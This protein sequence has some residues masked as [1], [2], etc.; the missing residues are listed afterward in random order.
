M[1]LGGR[2]PTMKRDTHS[3]PFSSVLIRTGA[4]VTPFCPALSYRE[5]GGTGVNVNSESS[6]SDNQT[7]NG[8]I[9]KQYALPSTT[10]GIEAGRPAKQRNLFAPDDTR[11]GRLARILGTVP[12]VTTADRLEAVK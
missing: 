12:G 9:P 11:A 5:A 3:H 10:E 1:R 8:W 4:T 7:Q 2:K 6:K